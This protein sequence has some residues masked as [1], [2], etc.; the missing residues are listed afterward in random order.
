MNEP[1]TNL[2]H[3]AADHLRTRGFTVAIEHPRRE[4]RDQHVDAWFRIGKDRHE[5]GYAVE[6]KRQVTPH[7][8]GAVV[9]QLKH[10]GQITKKPFLLVTNHITPP[11]ADQLTAVDQQFVDA[12]AMPTSTHRASSF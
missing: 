12:A 7:T 5:V 3:A 10:L 8:L 4:E 11:V 9:A 6:V 1:E 2:L